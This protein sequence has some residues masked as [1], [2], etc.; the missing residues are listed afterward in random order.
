MNVFF[1]LDFFRCLPVGCLEQ[2]F[3]SESKVSWGDLFDTVVA[4][5]FM[6]SFLTG[7]WDKR[8]Q[9]IEFQ[10][11]LRGSDS[12]MERIHGIQIFLGVHLRCPPKNCSLKSSNLFKR[13]ALVVGPTRYVHALPGH[14]WCAVRC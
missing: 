12:K 13:Q 10:C 4:D 3:F 5:D 1:S 2:F 14:E 9:E 7:R 11:F 6:T 8:G